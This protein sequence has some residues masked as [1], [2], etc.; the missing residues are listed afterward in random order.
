MSRTAVLVVATI[1]V[2]TGALAAFL[3]DLANDPRPRLTVVAEALV[4]PAG[5]VALVWW[6]WAAM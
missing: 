6:S 2:V 4:P 1:M 3:G 5:I